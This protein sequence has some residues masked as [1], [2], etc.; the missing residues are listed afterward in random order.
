MV[1]EIAISR[2]VAAQ[3]AT[4]RRAE[5]QTR[6]RQPE[7]VR[8]HAFKTRARGILIAADGAGGNGSISPSALWQTEMQRSRRDAL[9]FPALRC[10]KKHVEGDQT[11]SQKNNVVSWPDVCSSIRSPHALGR[12]YAYTAG[13]A[14]VSIRDAASRAGL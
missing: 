1:D 13:I 4:H 3:A 11:A 6:G 5:M 12:S 7:E 9:R 8:V 14:G 2:C 10:L